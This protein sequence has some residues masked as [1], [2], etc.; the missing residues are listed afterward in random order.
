[1]KKGLMRHS[2]K[3]DTNL[4][5]RINILLSPKNKRKSQYIDKNEDTSVLFCLKNYK[6]FV[7]SLRFRL[8]KHV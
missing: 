7:N 8:L 1:M 3:I 4:I 5:E 6:A 2:L